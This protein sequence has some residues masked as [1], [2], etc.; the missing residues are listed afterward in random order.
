M[1]ALTATDNNAYAAV[2]N[3]PM[4]GLPKAAARQADDHNAGIAPTPP[5]RRQ[6]CIKFLVGLF[7][8]LSN[9]VGIL[10]C[11]HAPQNCHFSPHA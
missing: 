2:D 4:A 9:C 1:R 7:V 11:P 6:G 8:G 5:C 3:L 10:W